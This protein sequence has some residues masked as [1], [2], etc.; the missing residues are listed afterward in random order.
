[1]KKIY[2]NKILNIEGSD[3]FDNVF[4]F[5]Y[6][7]NISSQERKIVYMRDLLQQYKNNGILQKVKEKPAMY[8]EVYS[9]KDELE[10]FTGL[11]DNAI[12]S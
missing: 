5:E 11:F 1:M 9:P 7:E 6:L 4:L 10:I 12:D 8:S 2:K 3:I